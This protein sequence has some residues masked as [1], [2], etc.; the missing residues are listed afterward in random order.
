MAI[1]RQDLE[2][3]KY[4]LDAAIQKRYHHVAEEITLQDLMLLRSF[5]SAL[6][7]HFERPGE[8]VASREWRAQIYSKLL[9]SPEALQQFTEQALRKFGVENLAQMVAPDIQWQIVENYF[10]E[11][12]VEDVVRQL[13]E[14]NRLGVLLEYLINTEPGFVGQYFNTESEEADDRFDE[15]FSEGHDKGFDQ[16][17]D[18]GFRD[19][20]EQEVLRNPDEDDE[21]SEED[22]EEARRKGEHDYMKRMGGI[23]VECD[24][25]LTF[26]DLHNRFH[27]EC[28]RCDA[29][30]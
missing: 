9:D 20:M 22:F 6:E 15:G 27:C 18:K 24:N 12:P 25:F 3:A 17:Y 7:E 8:N 4:I 14:A 21:Y 28:D 2:M 19:A 5:L 29:I 16:G 1:N 13:K 11:A 10:E 26:C 23:C 30:G